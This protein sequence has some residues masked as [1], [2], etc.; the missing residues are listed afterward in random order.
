[1]DDG[2]SFD[3]QQ[4]AYIHRR[5]SLKDGVLRSVDIGVKG[6]KTSAYLKSMKDVKV[7]RVIIVNVPKELNGMQEVSVSQGSTKNAGLEYHAAEGRKAAW[8]V[9]R[10]PDVSVGADWTI[11]Y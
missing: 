8:V 5:F 4:G 11:S 2:E 10:R 6:S 1:V 7:E 3:Y 9:V